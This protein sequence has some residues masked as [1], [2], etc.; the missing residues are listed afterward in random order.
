LTEFHFGS[1][2]S[3]DTDATEQPRPGEKTYENR[4]SL[5]AALA[6]DVLVMALDETV[7]AEQI[8][9]SGACSE[10]LGSRS[11]WPLKL[12]ESADQR[13]SEERSEEEDG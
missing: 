3:L 9:N 8:P 12:R 4:T 11:R 5:L 10:A 1:T 2:F 13:C 7:L 6:G